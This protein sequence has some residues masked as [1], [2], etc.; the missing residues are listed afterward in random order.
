MPESP[1]PCLLESDREPKSERV[2]EGFEAPELGVAVFGEH[3]VEMLAIEL[4]HICE[5]RDASSGAG[6]VAKEVCSC[7]HLGRRSLASCRPDVP[8]YMDGIRAEELSDGTG[9][10]AF[11]PLFAERVARYAEGFGCALRD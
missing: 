8:E 3:P 9:V 7:I 10:R 11:V 1:L 4:G 2:E 6:Y 5:L